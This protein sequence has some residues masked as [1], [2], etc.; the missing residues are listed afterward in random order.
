MES[1][2]V[3]VFVDHQKPHTQSH[4]NFKGVL[5]GAN[6]SHFA[7]KILIRQAAQKSIAMQ[8]NHNLLLSDTALAK[9]EPHLE[10][11]A[12]DVKATHGATIGHLDE[13]Q[14]FYLKSRGLSHEIARKLQIYGFVQ[15]I[16][17]QIPLTS[18]QKRFD[19]I[20]S[21]S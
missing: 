12:D 9:S 2:R 14:L 20:V 8:K 4:Q 19:E 18:I 11:F 6:R 7:G 1:A 13:E 16:I 15:E 21:C 5:D 10:I 17:R 3:T